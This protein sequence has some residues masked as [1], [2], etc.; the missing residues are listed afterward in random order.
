MLTLAGVTL[1]RQ[2]VLTLASHLRHHDQAFI[3]DTLEGALVTS[4]QDVALTIPHR[5]AILATLDEP[6]DGLEELRCVLLREL[7]GR[8]R[9]ELT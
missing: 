6:P 3:A 7:E 5:E 9:D 2:T 1:G 4:Q 8:R